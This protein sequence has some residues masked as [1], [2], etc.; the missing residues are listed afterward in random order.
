M[1]LSDP[2]LRTP[3][4]SVATALARHYGPQMTSYTSGYIFTFPNQADAVTG[5]TS[6][7]QK[8]EN[9]GLGYDIFLAAHRIE[10]VAEGPVGSALC[11]LRW[12]I[13]PRKNEGEGG[14]EGDVGR[15]EG[16]EWEN[17]YGF[18][19]N[20]GEELGGHWEFV[21]SDDEIGELM[22]RVPNFMEL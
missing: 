15:I 6:H 13:R 8:F 18:R 14:N 5:I 9:A 22:A 3:I 19:R 21:V 20:D 4:S 16:W 2:S 12:R 10:V 1:A 7:L 11:W 17:V